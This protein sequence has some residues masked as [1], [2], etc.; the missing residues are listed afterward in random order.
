MVVLDLTN[1]HIP[2]LHHFQRGHLALA[3]RDA[4]LGGPRLRRLLSLPHG[5]KI[6]PEPS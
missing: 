6:V 2:C 1:S 3:K 5:V 4:V